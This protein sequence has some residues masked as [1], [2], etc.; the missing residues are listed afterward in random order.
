[1]ARANAGND[2]AGF[3]HVHGAGFR[4]VYDLSNLGQSQMMIATGQS[5]HRLSAYYRNLAQPWR[6]GESRTLGGGRAE[7]NTRGAKTLVVR[8]P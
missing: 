4:A 7:L 6:D 5:G 3:T 1:M 2:P 8:P